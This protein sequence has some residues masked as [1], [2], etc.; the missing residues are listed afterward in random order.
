MRL[1]HV[2]PDGGGGGGG[3]F[4]GGK[5]FASTPAQKKKA[6]EFIEKH[7]EPDTRKAGATAHES[8]GGAAREFGPHDGEGWLTGTALKAAGKT[9]GEQLTTLMNRLGA[10]KAALRATHTLF[11]STDAGVMGVRKPSAMDSY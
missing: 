2:P 5:D 7:L 9:W 3:G 11:Q 10:E 8:T 6:A 4:E 1:N